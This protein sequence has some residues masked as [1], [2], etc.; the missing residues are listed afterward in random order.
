MFTGI[1]IGLILG[2]LAELL[3]PGMNPTGFI[4]SVAL[5][6]LGG[7]FA[8][9]FGWELHICRFDE[10]TAWIVAIAGAMIPIVAY[11]I[12]RRRRGY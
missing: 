1:M 3:M 5:G 8:L 6:V 12:T 9:Y 10:P 4:M 7:L 2:I 11:Q